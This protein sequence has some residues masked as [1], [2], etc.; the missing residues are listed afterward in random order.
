[1]IAFAIS[2]GSWLSCWAYERWK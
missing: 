2:P 1:V